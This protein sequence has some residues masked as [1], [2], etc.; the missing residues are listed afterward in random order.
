MTINLCFHG[1]GAPARE[2]EPG[3]ARYW[4]SQELFLRVLDEVRLSHSINLSFDDGNKSDVSI[5]LPALQERG[6]RAT[7][8]PLAGRLEDPDSVGASDLQLLRSA[9]MTVGS[10][11][12]AHVPWRGLDA[13]GLRRELVEARAVLTDASAGSIDAAALPLGRYDRALLGQLQDCGYATVFTS[14]RFPASPGRWLQ[15]R[16][17]VTANDNLDSIRDIITHR[18]GLDD[19]RH[20]V[21]SL[22]K[23]LR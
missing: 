14:D 8:F 19:A 17:S 3:E 21:S 12:W 2:R 5:A 4:V 22:V 20:Y 15:P 6:L 7:F 23:R 10:H 11:G 18:L 16:Y 1:I 13:D 9:G